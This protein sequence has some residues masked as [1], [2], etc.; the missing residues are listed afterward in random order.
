[1]IVCLGTCLKCESQVMR[2]VSI[3]DC[4]W[5]SGEL[6]WHV[7]MLQRG[8]VRSK[9]CQGTEMLLVHAESAQSGSNP[10]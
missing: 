2:I 7:S 6:K 9:H 8:G 4:R 3:L 10:L 1:M 5:G